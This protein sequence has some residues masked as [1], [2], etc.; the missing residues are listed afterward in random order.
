[1][2]V[3][4][5]GFHLAKMQLTILFLGTLLL[6]EIGFLTFHF[7]TFLLL[8]PPLHVGHFGGVGWHSASSAETLE[9]LQHNSFVASTFAPAE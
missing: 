2:Y 6:D 3:N 7:V 4:V 1:M 9:R 5:Y 8:T